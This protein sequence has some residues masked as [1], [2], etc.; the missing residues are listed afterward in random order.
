MRKR[1]DHVDVLVGKNIRVFRISKGLSQTALADALGITF[2]QVQKYEN[3]KNRVGSGRLAAI[4]KILDVPVNQF[5]DGSGFDKVDGTTSEAI[6]DLLNEPHA[7]RMP[8]FF[9]R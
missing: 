4:S 5:F 6:R 2:Q 8:K 3:G 9:Q 1:V 7:I